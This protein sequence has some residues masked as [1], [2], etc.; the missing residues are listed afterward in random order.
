MDLTET[1]KEEPSIPDSSIACQDAGSN[2]DVST[3]ESST[4]TDQAMEEKSVSNSNI[5][6]ND[7]GW[8]R[9]GLASE[10]SKEEKSVQKT[11]IDAGWNL[12]KESGDKEMSIADQVKEVAQ[13]ALKET[14]MVYVESAGMYYDYKTGYYYN[15]VSMA[16]NYSAF[17]GIT[18]KYFFNL[19][20]EIRPDQA[21][22][23]YV[24]YTKESCRKIS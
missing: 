14:G 13:N 21:P 16:S 20:C 8:N 9:K 15:S 5:S 11:T 7:A 2:T 18:I 22:F 1:V 19:L 4:Q 12:D 10:A 17:V 24:F 6:N 3:K 23:S